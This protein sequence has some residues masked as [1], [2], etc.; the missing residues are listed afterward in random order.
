MRDCFPDRADLHYRGPADFV[1]RHGRWYDPELKPWGSPKS[2]FGNSVICG[3][4]FGMRVV[5]GY[6]LFDEHDY[7]VHHAWNVKGGKA[8]DTTPL[9]E[10]PLA[11]FG[12]EFHPGRVDA[13][14]WHGD[15]SV[16]DDYHRGYPLFQ[17]PWKGEDWQREWPLTEMSQTLLSGSANDLIRLAESIPPADEQPLATIKDLLRNFGK[18][19]ITLGVE[20]E[21][22]DDIQELRARLSPEENA[23]LVIRREN[24]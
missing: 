18:G 2:C 13:A 24:A 10:K 1:L 4:K 11:Y 20:A 3:L 8:I 16:L 6:V 14:T 23:R 12:V 9:Y 17:Q 21:S 5:E 19:E 22:D 7:P 15:A